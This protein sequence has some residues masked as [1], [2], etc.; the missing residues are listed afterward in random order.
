MKALRLSGFSPTDAEVVQLNDLAML[1]ERAKDNNIT[2][3]PRKYNVGNVVLH[4]LTVGA[5]EWWEE[6]GK[7]AFTSDDDR[8]MGYFFTFA[9]ARE[10]EYLGTLTEEKEIRK[11]LKKWKKGLEAT[12]DQLWKGMMWCK[13]GDETPELKKQV[14]DCVEVLTKSHTIL[15]YIWTQVI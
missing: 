14:D 4:E 5:I 11:A 7:E 10:L 9:H 12:P 1:V 2:S 3:H 6:Y 8:V 13:F 15:D